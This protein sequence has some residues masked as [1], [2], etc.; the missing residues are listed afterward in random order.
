MIFL[1]L[2]LLAGLV[3]AS[4]PTSE[5]PVWPDQFVIVQ[6]RIPDD[7]SGNSTTVT[8]YDWIR[9]ANLIIITDDADE[10][11]PLWDLELGTGNSYYFTPT[12]KKCTGMKF[13]VGILRPNWLENATFVKNS[14]FL[15][16]PVNIWTKADFIDYYADAETCDPVSWYFHSMQARF[17]TIYYAINNTIPDSSYFEPPTFCPSSLSPESIQKE[18]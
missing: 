9:Q 1:L 3:D 4:C 8:Y 16:K 14:T 17:D 18:G 10:G 13:P 2:H 12:T 5:P 7:N 6:R 11:N 15:G